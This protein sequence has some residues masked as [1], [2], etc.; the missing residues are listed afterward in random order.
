VG[1]AAVANRVLDTAAGLDQ[2][3]LAE[4]ASVTQRA[5]TNPKA[6][7]LRSAV[8]SDLDLAVGVCEAN[9]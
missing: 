7:G 5:A 3:V 8:M 1:V 6:S 2:L 4:A 9:R